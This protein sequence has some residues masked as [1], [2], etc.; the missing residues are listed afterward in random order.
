MKRFGKRWTVYEHAAELERQDGVLQVKL[1]SSQERK[2][3]L[4]DA[5]FSAHQIGAVARTVF[6]ENPQS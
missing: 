5:K 2:V 1:V 6:E 4:N 3:V